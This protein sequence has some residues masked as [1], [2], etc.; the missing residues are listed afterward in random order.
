VSRH[1]SGARLSYICHIGAIVLSYDQPNAQP[2]SIE[3]FIVTK[4]NKN[5]F[6]LAASFLALAACGQGGQSGSDAKAGDKA[7][8]GAGETDRVAIV[9][10]STV[11][12]FSSAAAE[13]FAAGGQF[14]TPRVESTGTGG[15]FSVF[16]QGAGLETP[17]IANA[18]RPIK[19]SEFEECA[20]NGVTEITEVKIGY[21]G[22]VIASGKTGPKLNVTKYEIYQALAKEL[23]DP[24]TKAFVPNPN[25]MWN[26]INPALPVIKIDVM[27]PPPTSGTRDAFVELVME[28]GAVGNEYLK[29]LKDSNSDEFKKRATTLREDGAWKDSGENDN[30]I[31]QALSRSP[32]QFGVFGYSSFEENADRLQ[33]AAI[34]GVQASVAN[35]ISGEYGAARSLFFYIKK[36]HVGAVPGL[37]E[38]AAEM[39]SDQAAGARGYLRGRGM[40]PLKEEERVASAAVVSGMTTMTAPAK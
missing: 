36:A 30:L 9:G 7:K 28:K 20:K 39:V 15:G 13:K 34:D 33:E 6:F 22:I 25:T 35:I 23:Y 21:D 10:S 29:G 17:S 8:A 19:K 16:C 14:K 26:Q 12:P 5:M 1:I 18:S 2:S 24:G 3:V 32:E 37:K 27:G 38:F 4:L 11:F 40:V 31:V